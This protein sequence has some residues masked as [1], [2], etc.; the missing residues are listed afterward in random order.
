MTSLTTGEGMTFPLDTELR[1]SSE[2]ERC[3][4]AADSLEVRVGTEFLLVSFVLEEEEE[5]EDADDG[6]LQSW[7]W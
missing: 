2:L 1:E 7:A 6:D 3:P 5:E 4:S